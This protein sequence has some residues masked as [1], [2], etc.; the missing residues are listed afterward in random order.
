[1]EIVSDNG[2]P[3]VVALNYLEKKYD[4]KHI[5]IS[6]YNSCTN[7]IV[8]RSHFDIQQALFKASDGVEY[9]WS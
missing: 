2:K 8:K 9:K 4:I 6:S 7:G 5:Q 3:F 1:M